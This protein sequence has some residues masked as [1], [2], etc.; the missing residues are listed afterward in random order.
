MNKRIQKAIY[1]IESH[2]NDEL[3]IFLLADISAYS[4]FHFC[5]VF[6]AQ[7]G[8][9]VMSFITRLRLESASFDIQLGNKP[10]ID[11]ALNAGFQT[12]TGFLKAFKNRFDATPTDYK[13]I[14]M[15]SLKN[16]Q[17]IKMEMPEIVTRETTFVVFTREIGDY[18]KSSDIAW[19]RLTGELNRLEEKFKKVP[20]YNE[21]DFDEKKAELMG[22]IYDDPSIVEQEKLRYDAC[23]AW[24]E[25]E[26]IF[27]QSKGFET[28]TIVDGKYAK[29][30][31]KGCYETSD[32]S[33]FGLY[34][35]IEKNKIEL[36]D[37]PS[38]EK[39]LNT[40]DDVKSTD[41]LTEIYVPVV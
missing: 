24:S 12:Q 27:L 21:I 23:I 34:E 33:W 3:D 35:W 5:R 11:I 20:A 13:R 1:H 6:K 10:M 29:V 7:V 41:L 40:P 38:F 31:H 39:Y 8:E 2:L 15:K 4:R 17:E 36:R 26:I 25:A 37:K 32:D 22:I 9:S 19:G 30:L 16:Y 14:S 18:F 28:K